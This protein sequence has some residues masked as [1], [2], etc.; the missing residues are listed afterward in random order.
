[1]RYAVLKN[2]PSLC[3]NFEEREHDYCIYQVVSATK[4]L[5]ICNL[6][7]EPDVCR[8]S[9]AIET[10]NVSICET[11]EKYKRKCHDELLE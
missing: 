8:Y 2:E 3:K 6:S 9:F 11:I 5:K 4:N 7:N 10:R 1:M